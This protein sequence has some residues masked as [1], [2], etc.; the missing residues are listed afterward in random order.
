MTRLNPYISFKD[1]AGEA[2]E[3]YKTVFGGKLDMTTFK[4]GGVPG[5]P[6]EENKIMHSTLEA[7]NGVMFMSADTPSSMEYHP[8]TNVSISLS[9]GVTP[10]AC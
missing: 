1:N 9:G 2:M 8:G 10:S 5:N 4:E 3:F 7:D 6:S